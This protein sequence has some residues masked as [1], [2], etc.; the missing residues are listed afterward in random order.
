VKDILDELKDYIVAIRDLQLSID[1]HSKRLEKMMESLH[2][3]D[4]ESSRD[5]QTE[6][7]S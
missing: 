4:L 7:E 5:D 1:F 3:H 2:N 6:G